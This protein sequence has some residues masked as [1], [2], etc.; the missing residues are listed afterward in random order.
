LLSDPTLSL[1]I[2]AYNEETRLPATLV[3]V[4]EYLTARGQPYEVLVVVNGSTDR[5]AEVTKAAA[6]T[7][8][9]IRLIL[10]PLRG[11]GR[12]VR[13]GVEEARGEQVV[14]ADADC[15]APGRAA[16]GRHRHP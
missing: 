4:S 13:I 10:T 1:V 2:P 9:S 3:R 6:E 15:R 11:K 7:D 14:F 16:P 8:P 5:T 12:A